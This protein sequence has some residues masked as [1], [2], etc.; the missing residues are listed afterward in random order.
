V[1]KSINQSILSSL[2][3]TPI[4]SRLQH[5]QAC[6]LA[7][8]KRSLLQKS[9]SKTSST[10]ISLKT[11]CQ[12]LYSVKLTSFKQKP[13]ISAQR[14]QFPLEGLT[15]WLTPFLPSSSRTQTP[16]V[17]ARASKNTNSISRSSEN[18]LHHDRALLTSY[19]GTCLVLRLPYLS[20]FLRSLR[21][22]L[23]L[24]TNREQ[25]VSLSL[26]CRRILL[27]F[28]TDAWWMSVSL[29]L[30]AL[31]VCIIA[32]IAWLQGEDDTLLLPAYSPIRPWKFLCFLDDSTPLDLPV[33]PPRDS[34]SGRLRS[35]RSER[36]SERRLRIRHV[37]L[38]REAAWKYTELCWNLLLVSFVL[39]IMSS[40]LHGN[41]PTANRSFYLE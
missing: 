30:P 2:F 1:R 7:T 36:A 9:S 40:R 34:P 35:V 18:R 14:I 27:H 16:R 8:N 4:P 15:D 20:L 38:H 37:S 33:L 41:N 22:R 25:S 3:I 39:F 26:S 13:Q 11:S 5:P 17:W 29:S 24:E 10:K 32:A 12:K 6:K 19:R 31:S 28:F 21:Q 23:Q